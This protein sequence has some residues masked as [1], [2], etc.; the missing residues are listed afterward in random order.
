MLIKYRRENRDAIKELVNANAPV[1]EFFS[2]AGRTQS[3]QDIVDITAYCIST[4]SK[5]NVKRMFDNY[6]LDV[7]RLY[8][9]TIGEE[10]HS[11]RTFLWLAAI[12]G[13]ASVCNYLLGIGSDP[14]IKLK[15][16]DR[17]IH[18]VLR[19]GGNPEILSI[20]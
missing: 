20:L 18:D 8:D 2:Y 9:F 7:N 4:G 12:L 3:P 13:E 17:V 5:V 16:G 14:D 10:T 19:R 6:R 1:S 11:G 15:S